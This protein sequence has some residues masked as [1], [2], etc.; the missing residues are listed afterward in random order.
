[1]EGELQEVGWGAQLGFPAIRWQPGGPRVAAHLLR[2]AALRD[3]WTEL[4][5]F[6]GAGY[7]RVLVPFHSEQ[8]SRTIGY[9]YAAASPAIA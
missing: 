1:V 4:D 2:S 6:E 3:H 8:G 9:L 5:R 7:S